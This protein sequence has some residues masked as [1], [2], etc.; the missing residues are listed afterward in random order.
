MGYDN[1]QLFALSQ[2]MVV[3]N[4]K[5]AAFGEAYNLS[6]CDIWD[7]SSVKQSLKKFEI[8]LGLH[9]MELDF[10]WDQPVSE[11][12]WARV[13]EY[14][15]NDVLATEATF[16]D[17]HGDYTARLIL[18]ELSGL[19]VNDTTAKHTAKIIFGNERQPHKHFSYPDLSKEF[20]GYKFEMGKSE[21]KGENPGE[22]GYVYA[23]P[24]I[25]SNVA[26]LDVASMHPTS[27]AQL[28]FFGEYTRNFSDLLEA[29]LAIKRGDY[30]EAREMLD[31]RLAPYLTDESHAKDLSY[32]LKIVINIVYGLTSAKFDNP[33]RD[34]RNVDNVVAK[35]GALFMI[36][37]KRY[38]QEQGYTVVHIKTDSIK[39]ANADEH[40]IDLVANYGEKFGYDFEHEET[41]D[42]FCLVN[43][44][45]YVARSEAHGWKAVGAQ[46]QHPYVFKSLFTGEETNFDDL[47][48]TKQVMKGVMYLDFDA[49]NKP[50][51]DY[52]GMHFVGRI[53]RFVPVTSGGGI[54]YRVHDGKN[55][56]VSGTK[57][58][59][60][61]EAEMAQKVH[62]IRDKIDI[63]FFEK[64]AEDAVKTINK[65][66]DFEEFTGGTYGR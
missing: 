29:R 12:H 32:A 58:R 47:C 54:L 64:L 3:D 18:A 30:A 56:A 57:G 45:V 23:E 50:M 48:E 39:I 31:G 8:D 13:V 34:P 26:L 21:Y 38:V 16:E 4:N 46:F 62:D 19:S 65:F 9:H 17:R 53:G 44:A 27:L 35:R 20:P 28:N 41:Y 61:V 40:I 49:V 14:C 36:D 33:F 15:V 43:D 63:E 60:W 5:S 52:E 22:G 51:F 42:R 6:Y 37:L 2:K 7:F 55:Y 1:A 25:Y 10:P 24:G 59:L 66:G 11:E